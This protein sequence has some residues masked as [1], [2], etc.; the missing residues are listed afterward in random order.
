MKISKL[1][2]IIKEEV[3]KLFPR[4][5]ICKGDFIC[6]YNDLISLEGAP[7]IVGGYFNC[8][9]NDLPSLKG[10]PKIVEGNFG[11]A[12][13]DLISL[14]GA[15]KTVEGHFDCRNNEKKFTEEEVMAVCEVKGKIYV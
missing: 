3:N 5:K 7:K 8:R 1:I 4:I 10:A 6:N 9:N 12:N 14:E 2:K 11:C 13:N 15:P